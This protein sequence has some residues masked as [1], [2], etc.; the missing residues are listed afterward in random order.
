MKNNIVLAMISLVVCISVSFAGANASPIT[1]AY[2]TTGNNFHGSFTFDDSYLNGTAFQFIP[3]S[4]ITAFTF[5]VP[6]KTFGL[7]DLVSASSFI[8]NS[9][10]TT[11]KYGTAR[12][13]PGPAKSPN[14]QKS[15]L[16]QSSPTGARSDGKKA[17]PVQG[18]TYTRSVGATATGRPAKKNSF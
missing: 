4:T 18:H 2:T 7:E 6:G 15:K 10:G 12:G 11:R 13:A 9:A 17:A 5:T 16:K 3:H 14:T 1:F 8:F